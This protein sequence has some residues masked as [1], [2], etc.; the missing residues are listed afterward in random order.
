MAKTKAERAGEISATVASVIIAFLLV[1][2][3]LMKLA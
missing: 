2:P 3:L 1:L